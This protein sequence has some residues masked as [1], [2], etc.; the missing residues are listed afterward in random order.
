MANFFAQLERSDSDQQD[1]FWYSPIERAYR[2]IVAR[3]EAFET[4]HLELAYVLACLA[5]ST[6][7]CAPADDQAFSTRLHLA[8]E[9]G[10]QYR[11]DAPGRFLKFVDQQPK[12]WNL[13]P[14]LDPQPYF[15]G[16]PIVQSSGTG[17]TRMV[18]EL[19]HR[20]AV[21]YACFRNV[22]NNAN[23]G[24]PF[25]DKAV[26]NYFV[27]AH[28]KYYLYCDLQIACFLSAWFDH[29]ADR[30]TYEP[31]SR[32]SQ[33]L[34]DLNRLDRPN[35][36]GRNHDRDRLSRPSPTR[37]PTKLEA[38]ARKH[39]FS[40]Y[41]TLFDDV[42]QDSVM[43]LSNQLASVYRCFANAKPGLTPPI[44][45]AFDECVEMNVPGHTSGNIQVNSLRR[46][47][48]YIGGLQKEKEILPFW[49]I[50]STSSSAA[51][52]V[53]HV[54]IQ[55]SFRRQ[56]GAPIP[57]FVGFG[58]DVL[59]HERPSLSSARQALSFDELVNAAPGSYPR[60]GT[61]LFGEYQVLIGNLVDRHMRILTGVN[62]DAAMHVDSPSEP[63][64]AIAASLTMLSYKSEEQTVIVHHLAKGR[65]GAIL[66]CLK[67]KCLLSTTIGLL[68]RTNGELDARIILMAAWD[69]VKRN[70]LNVLEETWPSRNSENS[71]DSLPTLPTLEVRAQLLNQPVLLNDIIAN[72]VVLEPDHKKL[73]QDRIDSVC[74]KVAE[75]FRT[76]STTAADVR[77]G[78][79]QSRT[80][81]QMQAWTNYTH[82]DIVEQAITEISPEYLW[83]CWK[84]GVALQM[85]H[86]QEGM[87]GII[88]VFVGDLDM[89]FA[90]WSSVSASSAAA[91]KA[92]DR[93]GALGGDLESFAARRMTFVSWEAKNRTAAQSYTADEKQGPAKS[94]PTGRAQML[95]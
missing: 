83:Y 82:F 21:L 22:D 40:S 77:G 72:L 60:G 34:D 52:L 88:P 38:V 18:L 92:E 14:A 48:N 7:T 11:G 19:R 32:R 39:L 69:A 15:R 29:L 62:T 85:A 45:V 80:Q 50:L 16:T 6:P 3:P 33:S 63:V 9:F 25:A 28:R 67:R 61:T 17:K 55:S 2:N 23:A 64:L 94:T 54:D 13:L 46:A 37:L 78:V 74:N 36:E 93:S 1:E 35:Q 75:A 20:A 68:K 56:N 43:N 47:W 10:R 41:N 87:D 90:A 12:H 76:S 66:E 57:T 30:L 89:P 26:R 31:D 81:P 51:H 42:L 44:F 70:E 86:L 84:R 27:Q 8:K 65:Y 4:V 49:L 24:Y 5:S 71:D 58:F 79:A 73:I 59:A 95:I 53:E 91:R